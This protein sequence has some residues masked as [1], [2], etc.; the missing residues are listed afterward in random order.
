VVGK[1][2]AAHYRDCTVGSTIR[3]GRGTWTVVGIFDGAGSSFESEIWADV[4]DVQADTQRGAYYATARLKLAPG[5][6]GTAMIRRLADDPQINLQA[7]TETEYYKD[8]SVVA[9]QLRVL[10][11]VVAVIMGVGAMFAAM[12]TMYAS[13]A[14]RTAEI[15]TLRALGF[16]PGAV[17]GSFLLE[18]L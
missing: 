5:A 14:A 18:S 10:G 4:H 15:G 6:D 17:L 7:Q 9:N 3:F 8:Q 13:V 1:G 2:V 11:M 16:A 12:N